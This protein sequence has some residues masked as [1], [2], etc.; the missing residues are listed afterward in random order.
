V[1]DCLFYCLEHFRESRLD[2]YIAAASWYMEFWVFDGFN[3]RG[4]GGGSGVD[5]G[6]NSPPPTILMAARLP[7]PL[8]LTCNQPIP[9]K[10]VSTKKTPHPAHV[11]MT[12]LQIDLVGTTHVSCLRHTS[13]EIQRWIVVSEHN[14]TE[15]LIPSPDAP[16]ESTFTLSSRFWRDVSLPNTVTPSFQTCNMS[17]TYALEIKLGVSWGAGMPGTQAKGARSPQTLFL[18]LIFK[19]VAVFSGI[20]P[21]PT[22]A[23]TQTAPVD[24][25]PDPRTS[26]GKMKPARQPTSPAAVPP[27]LPPRNQRAYSSP[28]TP[29]SPS[30]PHS[31]AGPSG[32]QY[33]GEQ[34]MYDEPPPSYDEAMAEST[35]GPAGS[36]SSG[37]PRP[38]YSAASAGGGNSG[39]GEGGGGGGEGPSTG[40]GKGA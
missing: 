40:S 23:H 32:S 37:G 7:H 12:S 21:P 20:A 14:L 5:E 28:A 33:M 18:P 19:D 13:K 31:Q 9:L 34:P 26:S 38:T 25:S 29:A 8:V 15:P 1:K 24:F 3:R 39:G 30:G 17:R 6:V 27:A 10:L 35:T 16:E 11:Y 2:D 36:S 22:L 4:K